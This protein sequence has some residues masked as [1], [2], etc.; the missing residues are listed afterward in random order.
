LVVF[1]ADM[2]VTTDGG[3]RPHGDAAD[4]EH[5]DIVVW[6]DAVA[7]WSRFRVA[8]GCR[9]HAAVAIQLKRGTLDPDVLPLAEIRLALTAATTSAAELPWSDA[10]EVCPRTAKL[11]K[12]A[13][14]GWAPSTHWLHHVRVRTAVHTLLLVSERVHRQSLQRHGRR[15]V[16]SMP[17]KMWLG[18]M[19][20]VRR[21]DW[22]VR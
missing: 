7:G 6:L 10:P 2:T 4:Q 12:S 22:Q 14:Q 9:F 11:I 17:P 18:I 20:F 5:H 15:A 3:N 21:S 1:G 19:R 16:V 8:A 13:T